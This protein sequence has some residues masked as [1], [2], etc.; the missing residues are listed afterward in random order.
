[1]VSLIELMWNTAVRKANLTLV[2]QLNAVTY[3]VK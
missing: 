3:K 2:S 1:M